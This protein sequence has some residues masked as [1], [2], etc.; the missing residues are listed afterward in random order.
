M[1]IIVFHDTAGFIDPECTLAFQRLGHE[2]KT[3]RLERNPVHPDIT[4]PYNIIERVGEIVAF[5][6]DL[7]FMVNGN[8][9]D[10]RG[11]IPRI[12]AVLKIPLVLW[13]VDRPFTLENWNSANISPT[14]VIFVTDRTY[15]S[16]LKSLGLHRAF[17]L[18]LAT[19]PERF[20]KDEYAYIDKPLD[21]VFVGKLERDKANMYVNTLS[22]KWHNRPEGF[23]NLFYKVL[24][25]YTKRPELSLRELA[26]RIASEHKINLKFPSEETEKL[27]LNS[28][29]YQANAYHRSEVVK[30][31]RHFGITVCGGW[32]WLDVV[33]K[34]HYI[35]EVDYFTGLAAIYKR[36]VI[37]LNITRLQIRTGINQ[38]LLD[39]PAADG[40]LLTDYRHDVE[41]FFEAGKEVVCYR[42]LE[43][44]KGHVRYYLSHPEERME[45]VRAA[46]DKVMRRHTYDVRMSELI[47]FVTLS[48]SDNDYSR[49]INSIIRS[50]ALY[51]E[52]LNLLGAA[53][54]ENS[55][56][57]LA[58]EFF[59]LSASLSPYDQDA[60]KGLDVINSVIN[61]NRQ[62]SA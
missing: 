24:S 10:E 35:E 2:V 59:K 20:N 1:K 23:D 49:E 54:W 44:L 57:G 11:L 39:I 52:A 58:L 13:Y 60:R 16:D 47:R 37:N 17:F 12:A 31:L 41:E 48:M 22:E 21:V 61:R 19:N 32:E 51:V 42:N 14:T 40:F 7:I 9:I 29:E 4:L 5:M 33:D 53:A 28:I 15:V 8:G 34:R 50:D 6:P 43:E 62:V 55:Q 38:R 18:P 26:Y 45:I 46:K 25:T 56:A 3:I 27:F 36:A 30:S